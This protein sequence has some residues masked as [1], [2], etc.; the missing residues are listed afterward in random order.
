ML[1]A[2]VLWAPSAIS[3]ASMLD[4]S[5]SDVAVFSFVYINPRFP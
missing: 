4:I 5:K 1:I 3:T 2:Y